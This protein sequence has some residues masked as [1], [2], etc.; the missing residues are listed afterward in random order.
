[1]LQIFIWP[2]LWLLHVNIQSKKKKSSNWNL[3]LL[4]IW[5]QLSS[6]EIQ[7]QH[8]ADV[9][10]SLETEGVFLCHPWAFA[11]CLSA[12]MCTEGCRLLPAWP[13][14]ATS[15]PRC[16]LLSDSAQVH[17]AACQSRS[18]SHTLAIN[19]LQPLTECLSVHTCQNTPHTHKC[20]L[21]T[22]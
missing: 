13:W 11:R 6:I 8:I 12:S 5:G 20:T 22:K 1:M 14:A 21:P 17:A 9:L 2:L 18:L 3:E 19:T 4:S 16:G 15:R 10:I 7:G